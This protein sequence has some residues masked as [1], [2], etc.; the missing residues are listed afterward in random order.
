MELLKEA[1]AAATATAAIAVT[2]AAV[3]VEQASNLKQNVPEQCL[4]SAHCHVRHVKHVS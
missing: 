4:A 2:I 1:T 3:A